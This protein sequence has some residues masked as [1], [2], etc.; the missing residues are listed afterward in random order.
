[1]CQ[2]HGDCKCR[3]ERNREYSDKV[4]KIIDMMTLDMP[5]H[6]FEELKAK[7]HYYLAKEK[8]I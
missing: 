7:I 3:C 8:E 6:E 1:M 4:S 5:L 2:C